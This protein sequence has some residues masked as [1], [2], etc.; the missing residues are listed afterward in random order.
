MTVKN[1]ERNIL[2]L[3]P[4][5]RIRLIESLIS[6]LNKPDPAIER[7][8]ATESDKRLMAYKKGSVKGIAWEIVRKRFVK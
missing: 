7:A 3:N 8:W 2:K 6:S 5:E 1:I 4:L